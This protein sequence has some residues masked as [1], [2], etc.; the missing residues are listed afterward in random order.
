MVQ[1]FC[2]PLRESACRA[3]TFS[4]LTS[5]RCMGRDALSSLPSKHTPRRA[6]HREPPFS[7]VHRAGSDGRCTKVRVTGRTSRKT[8]RRFEKDFLRLSL[9]AES[10]SNQHLRMSD[11]RGNDSLGAAFLMGRAW[12]SARA[13]REKKFEDSCQERVK[14][15]NPR[16]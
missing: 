15:N 16:A 1:W 10:L 11:L 9:R 14:R 5:I 4:P 6:N 2:G 3:T 8:Y 12:K 7:K 13:A